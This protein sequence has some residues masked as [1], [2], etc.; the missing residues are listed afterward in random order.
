MMSPSEVVDFLILSM[1]EA[2]VQ[3]NILTPEQ[4]KEWVRP[5]KMI[6]PS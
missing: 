3:L 1:Q 2:A 6:G 4:F 5:E